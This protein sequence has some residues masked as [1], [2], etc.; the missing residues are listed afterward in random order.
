MLYDQYV[1]SGKFTFERS[2]DYLAHHGIKGQKWGI[3]RFQNPDGSLTPEGKKRYDKLT[4]KAYAEANKILNRTQHIPWNKAA[5]KMNG[6][7]IEKY[8][9]EWIKKHGENDF[10]NPKYY[11][12]YQK[13]WNKI[14][15]QEI[16]KYYDEI[17]KNTKEYK[18]AQEMLGK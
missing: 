9:K 17:L 6:G 14:Y 2:D 5:D 1:E 4:Q 15:N 18:L 10:E 13:L 16:D 8:N 11:N 3:R 7:L 12:D